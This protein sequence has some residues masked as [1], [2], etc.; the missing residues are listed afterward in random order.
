VIFQFESLNQFV[1]MDGHGIY[2]WTA[3]IV[4]SN[5]SAVKTERCEGGDCQRSAEREATSSQ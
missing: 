2:V 4:F 3:V 5:K 1:T